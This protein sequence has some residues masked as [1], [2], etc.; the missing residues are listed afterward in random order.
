ML[1]SVLSVFERLSQAHWLKQNNTFSFYW[2]RHICDI[3]LSSSIFCYTFNNLSL[4]YQLFQLL[5]DWVFSGFFFSFGYVRVFL[6]IFWVFQG[7]LDIICFFLVSEPNIKFFSN[8]YWGLP[9]T[10]SYNTRNTQNTVI[11]KTSGTFT[12]WFSILNLVGHWKKYQVVGR[13]QVPVGH[14]TKI[15]KL[16]GAA[17]NVLADFVP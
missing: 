8:I 5:Y 7:I 3:S 14:W 13:V 6:G 4:F 11:P 12:W 10:Q 17:K 15:I 2:T 16:R 1:Q 9:N